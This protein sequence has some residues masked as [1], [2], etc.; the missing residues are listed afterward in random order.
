MNSA[1]VRI[2][3]HKYNQQNGHK[4]L[5]ALSRKL[6]GTSKT[7]RPKSL[8]Q[9]MQLSFNGSALL[10]LLLASDFLWRR[11][12]LP[13]CS[14]AQW[15]QCPGR[16]HFSLRKKRGGTTQ[17]EKSS[18]RQ[19]YTLYTWAAW[20]S[21]NRAP[22][23][24]TKSHLWNQSMRGFVLM[25]RSHFPS[26]QTLG[27]IIFNFQF[28]SLHVS[29]WWCMCGNQRMTHHIPARIKNYQ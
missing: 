20:S 25:M 22:M 6:R 1:I 13:V 26:L 5:N 12:F 2:R 3:E 28:L 9:N 16:T 14:L 11:H 19:V 24:H 27:V 8:E 4:Q 18:R 29:S 7:V 17:S 10:Q 15:N 21:W 23:A